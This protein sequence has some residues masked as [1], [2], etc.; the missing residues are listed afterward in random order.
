MTANI[1]N[2][3]SPDD[4]DI[5]IDQQGKG[6]RIGTPCREYAASIGVERLIATIGA[7]NR[8]SQRVAQEIGLTVE[9]AVVRHGRDE[10]IHATRLATRIR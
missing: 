6:R 5:T 4:P 1:T 3:F 9:K 7:E 2:G 10:H 8:A